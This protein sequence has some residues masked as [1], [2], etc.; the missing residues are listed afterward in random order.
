MAVEAMSISQAELETVI[1][2]Y[3]DPTPA[4]QARKM[5]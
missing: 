1:A 4:S 2:K 3:D 5:L